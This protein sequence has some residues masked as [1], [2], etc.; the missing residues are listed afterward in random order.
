MADLPVGHCGTF[1]IDRDRRTSGHRQE[2]RLATAFHRDVPPCGFVDGMADCEQ[3]VV[4]KDGRLLH[5]EA[6]S[7][8]QTF[9]GVK[10][11]SGVVIEEHMVVV[12][13]AR[14]LGNR[15]EKSAERRERFP[16]D[17]MG[18][19]ERHAPAN[20]LRMRLD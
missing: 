9:R 13:R 7:D 1:V 4:A 19:G 20:G 15:I 3:S 10:H 8:S 6:F 2:L 17:R 11:H 12:E 18:V 14:V 16:V 5:P